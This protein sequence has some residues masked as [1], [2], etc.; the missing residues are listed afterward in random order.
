[1]RPP[2]PVVAYPLVKPF[3]FE[4]Q[5][6]LIDELLDGEVLLSPVVA[7][8]CGSEIHYFTGKKEEEKLR[9]RLP[10][11]LLHEG[12]CRVVLSHDS[13]VQ[14]GS[15]VVPIPLRPCGQCP[16]C[17]KGS[18]NFCERASFMAA[19]GDGMARSLFSYPADRVVRVPPGVPP[20]V[21]ALTE[22]LSIAAQALRQASLK[23]HERVGILG[24]GPI[25]YFV[26][27]MASL[28][29]GILRD[30]LFFLG[31]VDEKLAM[32]QDFAT[33]VNTRSISPQELASKLGRLQVC[34]ECVGGGVSEITLDQA[35]HLL[36]PLGSLY[37]LGLSS[38]K[39][40][41]RTI[42]VVNR[43]LT[44]QG[45]SRSRPEEY[46]RVLEWLKQASHAERASRVIHPETF[47]IRSVQ[48][49][50][51]AFRFA[52]SSQDPAKHRGRV[53]VN[54]ECLAD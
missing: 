22:P 30:N 17:L 12:V 47:T 25:G 38:G 53:M 37:V 26:L 24:D 8:I 14:E 27:I 19:T 36:E 52:E 34:F 6:R 42:E 45:C 4:K 7:G 1:M 35:I 13:S 43:G 32:G 33:P 49:L 51:E 23:G 41:V 2:F 48:D 16:A 9:K 21:A 5:A 39:V 31:V 46:R 11:C 50:E 10:M 54:L 28:L 3:I 15:L 20:S 18:E 44:I 40:P 29:G